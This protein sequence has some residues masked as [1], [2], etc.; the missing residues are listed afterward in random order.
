MRQFPI[1]SP[2]DWDDA[3]MFLAVA[4][5]G[6]MLDAAQALDVNQATLSRQMAAFEAAL[7][8]KLLAPTAPN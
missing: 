2:L 4:R 7:G 1:T 5:A 6:Q 8:A 3:R